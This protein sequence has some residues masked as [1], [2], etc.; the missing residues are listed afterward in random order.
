MKTLNNGT[1]ILNIH[2]HQE[3]APDILNKIF[4]QMFTAG[5]IEGNFDFS[6]STVTIN[7]VS[8]LVH[9]QNQ[10]D[11]LVRIDTTEAITITKTSP[12]SIYLVARYRWEN[13]NVG[14]EFLFVDDATV[15]GTDVILVGLT[16]D[17]DGKITALNYDVQER[18]RLKVIQKDTAFPLIAKLDGYFPGHES[19]QLPISDG[20]L[21]TNLNAQFFNGK[22]ITE[23]VVSK[24]VSSITLDAGGNT[25]ITYPVYPSWMDSDAVDLG[26][27]VTAEYV[28]G[29]KI[30]PQDGATLPGFQDQIPVA[31]TVLQ[32]NLNAEFVG[33]YPQSEFSKSTHVHTLDEILDDANPSSTTYYRVAGVEG[34]TPTP[35]SIEEDD[36][37]YTNIDA[38]AYDA[39]I[40]NWYQ[41]VY[42]T[43]SFTLTG[44]I[45]GTVPLT[46]EMKNARVFLQ[47]VPAVGE[48]AIAAGL[49][50][51]Y[52]KVTQIT[53][54]FFKAR[55]MGSIVKSGSDY[56]RTD[57]SDAG[58]NQYY[59]FV[60]GEI[61]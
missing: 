18:A 49:E 13:A 51:R 15:I 26:E 2:Y 45:V 23:Y 24:D 12:T 31:N 38:I 25:I 47:R 59:Y 54:T 29:K 9:P 6:P 35:D 57:A 22:E 42:E 44:N 27:G 34:N 20:E 10:T 37:E 53:N 11:L 36:I 56:K 19:S 4:Y 32:K 1:E 5:L 60:I 39:R 43:G 58:A 16:L 17:Q 14:A 55:Q 52:A 61:I 7:V 48:G 50:K 41:P 33:N 28:M 21:N 3:L 40:M 8:F 30:Q 46:R